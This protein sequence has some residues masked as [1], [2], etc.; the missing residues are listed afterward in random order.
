MQ[1]YATK[2]ESRPNKKL[3]LLLKVF[4]INFNI[5]SDGRGHSPENPSGVLNR[6]HPR[7]QSDQGPGLLPSLNRMSVQ[8]V[9]R[10]HRSNRLLVPAGLEALVSEVC[11]FGRRLVPGHMVG[12]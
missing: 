8:L 12:L 4:I 5:H 3:S 10:R 7:L 9:L 1:K 2:P 6:A 11:R